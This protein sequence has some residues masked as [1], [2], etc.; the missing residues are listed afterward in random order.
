[1]KT[2]LLL[3]A[4]LITAVAFL[5]IGVSACDYEEEEPPQPGSYIKGYV[6]ATG[7]WLKQ[8]ELS[9]GRIWWHYELVGKYYGPESER[10]KELSIM[11]GDTAFYDNMLPPD[12]PTKKSERA[13]SPPPTYF[14]PEMLPV[15]MHFPFTALSMPVVAIDAIAMDD[16]DDEHP[17]G[18][19]LNDI[20]CYYFRTAWNYIQSGYTLEAY[21][22]MVTY[23]RY[24]RL[25]EFPA[26]PIKLIYLDLNY[27]LINKMPATEGNK[28]IKIIYR[29]EGGGE[30]YGI[31]QTVEGNYPTY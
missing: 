5:A 26:D 11:Y 24:V 25:S 29:F 6:D 31:L 19:S 27:I 15:R 8:R 30:A 2:K 22:D 7:I 14:N 18:S 4:A 17:K 10:F 3:H 21:M 12:D 28:R 9:E 20:T 1:M 16:Y 13:L 23:L